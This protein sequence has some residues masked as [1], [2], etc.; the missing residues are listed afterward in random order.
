SFSFFLFFFSYFFFTQYQSLIYIIRFLNGIGSACVVVVALS[1]F[2]DSIKKNRGFW[3]G[4]FLSLGTIG[5]L[6]G[7][8]IAGFIA[9]WYYSKML[10]LAG[11]FF[12]IVSIF[13]LAFIPEKKIKKKKIT[14]K[15]FNLFLEIKEY[16][17]FKE[18]QGMA[19]L[20]ILMNSK[21]QIYVIFFPILVIEN[22]GL[23]EISLGILLSIPVFFHIFQVYF[24][25]IADKISAEFGVLLGVGL[26]ASAFLIIPFANSFIL[27]FLILLVYGIGGSIWNVNAWSLMGR[28]AKEKN[29][30]G[31][32][33][34]SYS[35]LSKLGMFVATLT[36]AGLVGIFGIAETL[37]LF[38]ILIV[39]GNV[40]A[41]FFFEPIFHHKRNKSYF[42]KI[43]EVDKVDEN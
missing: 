7:P 24:G 32:V 30:E 6:L 3:T 9:N 5:A 2:E 1:A 38:A 37:Q 33:I 18:L 29:I 15:D 23:N 8:I 35:S 17:K 41:Y 20:G 4:L 26:V 36:S 21:N 39:I 14:I 16:L 31:E 28:I 40:I 22:L 42:H 10:L 34:G 27:L 43:V 19:L 11:V 12:S 13:L 25:K